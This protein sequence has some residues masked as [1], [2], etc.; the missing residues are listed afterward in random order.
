MKKS[1]FFVAAALAFGLA[2]VTGFSLVTAGSVLPAAAQDQTGQTVRFTFDNLW[3]AACLYT[4][5][6]AIRRVEGVESVEP[7]AN[8]GTTTVTFDPAVTSTAEIALA[9]ASVGFPARLSGD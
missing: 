2:G 3:C 6:T 1:R 9:S 4:A 5:S 7:D 8:S